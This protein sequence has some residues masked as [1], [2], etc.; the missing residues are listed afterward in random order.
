MTGVCED[1][2]RSPC[3]LPT[4]SQVFYSIVMGAFSLGQVGPNMTA[5]AS[6][7]AAA[8]RIYE[9]ID[10][11]P[12]IDTTSD[13]GVTL[14]RSQVRGAISFKNVT[15]AYP[16]RPH[17]PVL[18]KFSVDIKPGETVAFVGES[19]SGK[20]TLLQLFQRFYDPQS[21]S[22]E[23]DGKPLTGL[24]VQSLRSLIG[25]VSQE[26]ALF[27]MSIRDNI[28]LGALE[29]NVEDDR[30]R[31]AAQLASATEFIE[32][33]AEKYNT[34]VGERGIQLSG[35]Q[36]Q[37]IAI[38]RAILRNPSFLLLDEATSALD[39]R[40]E[41]EVQKALDQ[42]VSKGSAGSGRT[43]LVIAHRLSTVA[44]VDRIIVLHQG[45]IVEEG[46]PAELMAKEGG[47]YR[48]L[49]EMQS[50]TLQQATPDD[51]EASMVTPLVTPGNVDATFD[52]PVPMS[53]DP[54]APPAAIKKS[55]SS[56]RKRQGSDATSQGAC[57]WCPCLLFPLLPAASRC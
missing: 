14:N 8:A 21:G 49:L 43:T 54:F 55:D 22:I 39:S 37:R 50:L 7:R 13:R 56:Q 31:H 35:G 47:Y 40:S 48:K 28:A 30:I 33:L 2:A 41:R 15:F 45:S 34:P 16:S 20:S 18:S 23:V 26:P 25:I 4:T 46:T 42:L 11:T 44:N 29:E 12:A 6:A 57:A 24:N 52:V 3:P 19:G 32:R 36:K 17:Q 10:R 38:A 27:A 51:D 1:E 53:A 9:V 5:F